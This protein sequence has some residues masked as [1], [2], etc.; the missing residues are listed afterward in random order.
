MHEGCADFVRRGEAFYYDTKG[1]IK[2]KFP[3]EERN[4]N[5]VCHVRPHARVGLDHYELPIA[6]KVIGITSYT[7][8]SF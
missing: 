3:K 4:S 2:D 5:G 8:Q 1:K 6:D 7:K